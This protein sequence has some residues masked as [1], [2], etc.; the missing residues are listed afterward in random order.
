MVAFWADPSTPHGKIL[1]QQF[2]YKDFLLAL[3]LLLD[4]FPLRVRAFRF[5]PKAVLRNWARA[6]RGV[7]EAHCQDA[8]VVSL[9]AFV[10]G[11]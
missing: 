9:S 5:A 2:L 4:W 10:A 11:F 3:G 6:K 1:T 7:L 8:F